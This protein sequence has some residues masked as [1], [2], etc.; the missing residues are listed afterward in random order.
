MGPVK[1][2]MEV[3]PQVHAL[4]AV[5]PDGTGT[6]APLLCFANGEP[7]PGLPPPTHEIL[8]R[9]EGKPPGEL[10]KKYK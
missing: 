3:A 7:G 1:M 10:A 5:E 4:H 9:A 8:F 2:P 6:L